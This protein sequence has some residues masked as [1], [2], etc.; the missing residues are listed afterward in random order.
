MTYRLTVAPNA[1]VRNF[2]RE[3]ALK[4]LQW[5]ESSLRYGERF[6]AKEFAAA[7]AVSQP[8]VVEY[9]SKFVELVRRFGGEARRVR[10][11]VE[12]VRW[13]DEGVAGTIHPIDWLAMRRP[14]AVIQIGGATLV[15]PDFR[16][17]A[18]L[19]SAILGQVTV[20]LQDLSLPASMRA[21]TLS[22]AVI[23]CAEGIRSLRGFNHKTNLYQ[24]IPIGRIATVTPAHVR[25]FVGLEQ[26]DAWNDRLR[27]TLSL[28]DDLSPEARRG[29]LLDYGLSARKPRMTLSY[30]RCLV[31]RELRSRGIDPSHGNAV[32]QCEVE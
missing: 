17:E 12:V 24:E 14:E 7:H 20:D 2:V 29:A 13:P 5:I 25:A 21:I 18:A 32:F 4:R 23:V 11:Q 9:L 26:D 10:G 22:P 30:R 6:A 16:I 3:P 28:R 8:A 31:D 19:C 27:V 15:E 1:K